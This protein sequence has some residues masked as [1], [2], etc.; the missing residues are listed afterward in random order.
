[1]RYIQGV[2]E[3]V[4][5]K[6][7]Q[8]GIFD[9]TILA[10]EMAKMASGGQFVNILCENKTLRRPISICRI[11]RETGEIRLVFEIRGE[12]T[13]WLS[14]RWQGDRIDIIGPLGAA[15]RKGL[16]DKKCVVVGGGIGVP[17]MLEIADT[18]KYAD[19]ILGF[20]NKDRAILV[21]DFEKVCQSVYLCSDDGTLARKCFVSDILKEKIGAY[22]IVFACGPHPMLKAVADIAEK[23]AKECFVSLEERMGCGI[24]ACL[25]CACKTHDKQGEHYRHICKAGPIFNASEVEW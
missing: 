13:F 7:L 5:K 20:R 23:A 12:G 4:E 9:F 25:C 15:F 18:F 19:A 8:E 24:G 17:P 22:D 16:E 6:E 21:P 1:M 3:I 14:E 11:N 10:P 2:F